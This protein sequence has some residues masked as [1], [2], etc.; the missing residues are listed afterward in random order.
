MR[1]VSLAHPIQTL[2]PVFPSVMKTFVGVYRDHTQSLRP[3]GVSSQTSLIVMSDHA[4]THVDAPLHF[5]PGG[6]SIEQMPLDLMFGEAVML[7]FSHKKGG[8]S[9]TCED[10]RKKLAEGKIDTGPLKAIL[11]KTG[12]APLY[13]TEEYFKYY[14][15]IHPETVRWMTAEG[16][17]LWGVDASTIDH[18]HNK[19]THMLL[20]EMEFYHMENLA[21]LDALP[22]N[23][24]FTLACVSLPYVG[25]TASPLRP[26]AILND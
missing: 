3:A 22:E 21:N 24:P 17:R 6:K 8:D 1:F 15:E 26:L 12:A 25:A 5:A 13:G 19:A 16:I 11:F 7:D 18:A 4:G 2:M 23:T 9:V 10:L 14:L 20:R